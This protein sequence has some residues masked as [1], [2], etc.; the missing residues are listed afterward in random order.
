MAKQLALTLLCSLFSI[1][2]ISSSPSYGSTIFNL[3]VH[4][5]SPQKTF[6]PF[7]KTPAHGPSIILTGH[8][9][10]FNAFDE[11]CVFT[12]LEAESGHIVYSIDVLSGTTFLNLPEELSG[13]FHIEF[14]FTEMSYWGLITL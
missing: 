13:T 1:S 8:T 4:H 11:D 3:S 7:P 2:G 5:H 9:I 12:I 10:M 14:V 6:K